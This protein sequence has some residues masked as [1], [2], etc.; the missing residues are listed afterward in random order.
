MS[1]TPEYACPYIGQSQDTRLPW[2]GREQGGKIGGAGR[3][4]APGGGGG[5]DGGSGVCG[6]NDTLDDNSMIN[7]KK[8]KV[9]CVGI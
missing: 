1:I 5:L 3:E 4:D 6:V 7:S 9:I 8:K 2:S